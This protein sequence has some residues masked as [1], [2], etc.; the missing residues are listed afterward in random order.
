MSEHFTGVCLFFTSLLFAGQFF[1]LS[2]A[3][4]LFSFSQS[5]FF[6]VRSFGHIH[7]TCHFPA[8]PCHSQR[9]I[10]GKKKLY[11]LIAAVSQASVT[12]QSRLIFF[13]PPWRGSAA[14]R[15]PG[16]LFS[17]PPAFQRRRVALFNQ[18]GAAAKVW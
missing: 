8:H 7:A 18:V 14:E 6:S 9:L 2:F 11:L 1:P 5:V 4:T 16:G 13:S 17:L 12:H 15:M 10:G 3:L